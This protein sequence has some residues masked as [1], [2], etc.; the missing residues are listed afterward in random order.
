MQ[1]GALKAEAW[2]S[3]KSMTHTPSHI[4][5]KVDRL[6]H[7]TRLFFCLKPVPVYLLL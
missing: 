2:I 7:V 5:S 4:W 6:Q 3:H 1:I